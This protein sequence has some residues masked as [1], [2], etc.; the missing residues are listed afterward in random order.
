M[1]K[2]SGISAAALLFLTLGG[3][4]VVGI[5]N[6][7]PTT[8]AHSSTAIQSPED[9]TYLSSEAIFLNFTISSNEKTL[10]DT[11]YYCIIDKTVADYAD[12]RSS[13]VRVF[14]YQY[15]SNNNYYCNE[16]IALPSLSIGDHNVTVFQAINRSDGIQF[17]NTP[18]T[19]HFKV[20]S[21]QAPF[22]ILVLII[23]VLIIA[24]STVLL[25]H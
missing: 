18:A 19:F 20:Q 15:E 11:S 14:P 4:L 21:E 6:A 9:R 16:S 7:N 8:L 10:L 23:L 12:Y 24:V 3:F 5:V 22:I 1:R 13:S 2:T 17:V 25:I